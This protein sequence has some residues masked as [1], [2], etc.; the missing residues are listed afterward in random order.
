MNSNE[1]AMRLHATQ[2][3]RSAHSL[4][5]FGRDYIVFSAVFETGVY[6]I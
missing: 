2:A 6:K 3:G 1:L 4:A 5:G